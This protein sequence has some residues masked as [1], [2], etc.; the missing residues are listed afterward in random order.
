MAVDTSP[1]ASL[2]FHE[3][4][5]A[6]AALRAAEFRG[7]PHPE[8]LRLAAKVIRTRNAMTVDR[9]RAGWHPPDDILKHLIVD[10]QLLRERDDTTLA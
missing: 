10:E 4:Q 2:P 3:W 9:L 8:I 6:V 5:R 1:P 7:D